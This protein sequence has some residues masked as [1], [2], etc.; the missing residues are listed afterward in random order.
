MQ[1]AKPLGGGAVAKENRSVKMGRLLLWLLV[2][3]LVVVVAGVLYLMVAN[4]PAPVTHVEHV[5]PND[6]LGNR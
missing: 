2:A 4:V 6:R 5:I 1:W 3:V